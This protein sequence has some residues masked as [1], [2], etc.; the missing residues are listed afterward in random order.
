MKSKKVLKI[1]SSFALVAAI[2]VGFTLALL[3]ATTDTKENKFSSTSKI[4]GELTEEEFWD[5]EWDDYKP[6]DVEAKTPKISLHEGSE[7]A[8]VGMKVSFYNTTGGTKTPI[9]MEEFTEKFGTLYYNNDTVLNLGDEGKTWREVAVNQADKFYVYNEILK[10]NDVTA[11]L[12]DQVEINTGIYTY[13]NLEGVKG[14]V[15]KID[16][17]GNKTK[18]E[19]YE[20]IDE[21]TKLVLVENEGTDKETTTEVTDGTLLPSFQIDVKGY[22]V[23]SAN[24][25]KN[26]AVDELLD[27]AELTKK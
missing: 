3:T 13:Y 26:K 17:D 15:Y 18:L 10:A 25:D 2:A 12:F 24:I 19:E 27:L 8:W 9:T 16:E 23:Q 7:D 21:N 14:T 1:I 6:G 22:A 5:E 20:L 4:T 11:P